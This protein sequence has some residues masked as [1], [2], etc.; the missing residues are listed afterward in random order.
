[1]CACVSVHWK[2]LGGAGLNVKDDKSL[3]HRR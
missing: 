3:G 1:M 2:A